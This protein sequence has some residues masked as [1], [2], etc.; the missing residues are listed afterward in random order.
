[1]RV[2]NVKIK[3]LIADDHPIFRKGLKMV[4]DSVKE[5]EII[6]EAENGND[7]IDKIINLKPDIAVL[8][9]DM[10]LKS[11]VEVVESL[12]KNKST[13]EFIFLT[14]HKEKDLFDQ[15]VSLNVKGYI[16]KDNAVVEITNCIKA[17]YNKEMYISPS[18]SLFVLQKRNEYKSFQSSYPGMDLLTPTENVV[19]KLVADYKTNKEIA[20]ELNISIRTVEHHRA[21]ICG[22][23]GLKGPQ[24]LLKFASSNKS[25]F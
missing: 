15:A 24:A 14:M 8:D 25:N 13:T 7:A 18:L 9:V 21:N 2:E 20:D 19:L 16:L 22:K 5:F 17:V 1:M 10:P 11:G 3:I 4:L 12:Q 23:L 6:A